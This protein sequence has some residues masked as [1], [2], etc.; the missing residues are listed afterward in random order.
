MTFA[1]RRRGWLSSALSGGTSAFGALKAAF[2]RLGRRRRRAVRIPTRLYFPGAALRTRPAEAGLLN[3]LWPLLIVPVLVAAAR[4]SGWRRITSSGAL[5]GLAG[6]GAAV[7]RQIAAAVVF[8]PGQI[9]G[10]ARSLPSARLLSGAAYSVDVTKT[11]GGAEPMRVAGLFALAHRAAS[12]PWSHGL[13][14]TTVWPETSTQMAG[15]RRPSAVGPVGGCVL[16]LGHRHESAA[17]IRVLG[18][19]SYA[20]AACSST[21]FFDSGAG[22]AQAERHDRY[23]GDPGSAGGGPDRG[24]GYGVE[25]NCVGWAKAPHCAVPTMFS[26]SAGLNWWAR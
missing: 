6:H 5:L 25:A 11:Q 13:I 26:K 20:N 19:A 23:R 16:Y 17:T 18:A 9:P 3:Y 8:A 4:R 21:A 1:D 7:R 10:L 12:R 15:H 2:D 22:F 24:E 14:E